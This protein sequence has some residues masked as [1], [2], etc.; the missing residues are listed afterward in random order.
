MRNIYLAILFLSAVFSA[1]A[2]ILQPEIKP[3]T[4]FFYTFDLHGQHAAFDVT[5]KS[6]TDTLKLNWKIRN[7]ATGNYAVTPAAWQHANQLNFAQPEPFK[8]V[9]LNDQQTFMMISKAAYQNLISKKQYTYDHTIYVL[10]N[11]LKEN[12]L[13]LGTQTLDV[14]HVVAQNETTEIWILNNPDFPIICRIKGNLLGINVD[15]N[16]IK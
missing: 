12:P 2:Q 16:A 7:L 15:L 9:K 14:L 4:T 5:V 3:G 11:D 6:F 8:T 1:K 13:Q 10:K